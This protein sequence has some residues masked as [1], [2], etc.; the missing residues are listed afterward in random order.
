MKSLVDALA[1][2]KI[3]PVIAIEQAKDI[4]P[5]GRALAHNG[6]PAAEITFRS[7]AAAEAIARLRDDQPDMLIG[8]GTVL[9]IEQAK[10]AQAAGAQFVVARDSIPIQ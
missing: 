2:V 3:I 6:L 7:A 8:A 10:Q 5:I 1:N 4:I 9:N